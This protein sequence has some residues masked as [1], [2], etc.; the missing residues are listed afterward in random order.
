MT[1]FTEQEHIG[2]HGR[3]ITVA[4]V[5]AVAVWPDGDWCY[6]E[7][8]QD[9]LTMKSDDFDWIDINDVEEAT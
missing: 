1:K 4:D 5:E 3:T 9:Y 2:D 6:A 8:L 7:D